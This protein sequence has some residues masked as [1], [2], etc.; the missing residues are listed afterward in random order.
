MEITRHEGL[1]TE[2]PGDRNVLSPP[3][4]ALAAQESARRKLTEGKISLE[5]YDHIT[6]VQETATHAN[7]MSRCGNV[8]TTVALLQMNQTLS[9]S[10]QTYMIRRR[11]RDFEAMNRWVRDFRFVWGRGYGF[12]GGSGGQGQFVMTAGRE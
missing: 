12:W 8:T 2:T 1:E 11:Y 10:A 3:S 5:E 6:K 9:Q 7:A 4:L